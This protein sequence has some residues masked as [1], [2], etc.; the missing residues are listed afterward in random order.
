MKLQLK[1]DLNLA[2][3]T[4]LQ[5][6]LDTLDIPHEMNGIGEVSIKKDISKQLFIDLRTALFKYG[7]EI[8]DNPKLILTQKIKDLITEVVFLNKNT[9]NLKLSYYLG[10]KLN[11]SYN[12]LSNVFSEITYSSIENYFILQKIERVKE[13]I[14]E[15]NLSF[16][17][18]AYLLNYSSVAH[19]STQFKKTTGLS[20][21]TFVRIVKKRNETNAASNY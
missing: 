8:V 4:I 13:L 16:T 19:L 9:Q 7:I 15:D 17:E 5:E 20:P 10:E 2:C 11:Y 1:Y 3:K 14:I 12:Y 18:I 21:S 6:Q